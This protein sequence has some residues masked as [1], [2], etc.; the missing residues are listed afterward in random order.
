MAE[1]DAMFSPPR[2]AF[3]KALLCLCLSVLAPVSVAQYSKLPVSYV[4]Q[5]MVQRQ[6]SW[7]ENKPG[8]YNPGGLHFQFSKTDETASS[9]KRVAHYRVY[10]LG[11]PESKKYSLTVWRIGSEPRILSSNVYV[12]AKGLLMVHPPSL[13][14][15]NSDF[16]GDEE[17]QLAMQAARAEPVRYALTSSD[18]ELLVYGTVVPFPLT[19]TG[20]GCQLEVRLAVA[21]ATVVLIYADGLPANAEIPFQQLSANVTRT[22]NFSV[23]AQGHAVTMGVP[24]TGGK[25]NGTLRVTLAT[26]ECSAAV[27]LPWGEGSYHPM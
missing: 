11:A 12:N 15:E 18:K 8:K 9:G 22:E 27:E 2:I 13:E 19:D 26:T 4:T 24:L 17:F 16:L 20:S 7:D 3:L 5:D 1:N 14:Q 21:D 25:E 23:N 10:V 6:I